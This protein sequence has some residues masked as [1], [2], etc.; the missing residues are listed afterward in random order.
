MSSENSINPGVG[1]D[2]LPIYTGMRVEVFD[3]DARALFEARMEIINNR[4]AVLHRTSDMFWD[5]VE[6][7]KE[8]PVTVRGFHAD[9]KIGVYLK[10]GL[11]PTT[12]GQDKSWMFRDIQLSGTDQGRTFYRAPLRARGWIAPSAAAAERLVSAESGRLHREDLWAECEVTNVST[13][14]VRVRTP[15]AMEPGERFQIRFKLR[16]GKEQP[17]LLCVVRSA[18][19]RMGEHE[20][21]CEF[22][23]K[24]P[25]T[26][27]IIIKTV[28]ELQ[29]MQQLA[30]EQAERN[31]T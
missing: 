29:I 18:L 9:R 25:E 4:L 28:I 31:R 20:Y 30:E 26:E 19:D 23:D 24:T 11:L 17:P 1:E 8:I 27:D 3:K 2:N 14:G 16:R 13:G 5:D 12:Q 15:A 21:G 10:G 22:A 7:E 6:Q